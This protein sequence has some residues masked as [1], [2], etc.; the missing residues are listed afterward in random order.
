MSQIKLFEDEE[1]YNTSGIYS[2]CRVS[3]NGDKGTVSIMK[4][5]GML[6]WVDFDDEAEESGWC[7]VS[8]LEIVEE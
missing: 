2:G 8:T 5:N 6:A 7:P 4:N 3:Q 1:A